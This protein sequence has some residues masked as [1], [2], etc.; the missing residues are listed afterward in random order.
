MNNFNDEE[1]CDYNSDPVNENFGLADSIGST[2]VTD[3]HFSMKE[4]KYKDNGGT[5]TQNEVENI[6]KEAGGSFWWHEGKSNKPCYSNCF[7]R[8]YD[9]IYPRYSSITNKWFDD[10]R[11]N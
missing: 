3:G 10:S 9:C 2:W 5:W 11:R 6:C 8:S 4:K 1:V 7:N